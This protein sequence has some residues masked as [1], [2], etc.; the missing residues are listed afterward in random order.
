M[1]PYWAAQLRLI[2]AG[3]P[4]VPTPFGRVST[5]SARIGR[6]A[7]DRRMPCGDLVDRIAADLPRVEDVL[8]GL[9]PVDLERRGVHATRGELT[10][11]ASADRFLVTHV[12]EHVEQLQAILVRRATRDVNLDLTD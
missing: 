2:V 8:A 7:A 12:A 3:D 4:A 5:D 9:T 10:V 11:G 6:I 1:L